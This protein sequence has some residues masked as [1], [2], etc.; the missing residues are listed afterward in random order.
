MIIVKLIEMDNDMIPTN[1][2][3]FNLF[4]KTIANS[5]PDAETSYFHNRPK[6]IERRLIHKYMHE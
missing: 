3:D 5:D 4:G 2:S 1:L 6:I